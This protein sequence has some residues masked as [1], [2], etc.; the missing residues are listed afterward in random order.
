MIWLSILS[1]LKRFFYV[2]VKLILENK[3]WALIIILLICC[4]FQ[5]CQVNKLAGQIITLK[6]QHA[7]YITQQQ[8]ATEKA[9]VQAAQQEKVWA[10]QITKAEQ[11][12][13]AK[14]KQIQSDASAAQSAAN[15]LSKQLASAK[16]RLSAASRETIIEYTNTSSD[17][18]ESCI[19][20]YRN[21]AQKAD[22]HAADAERLSEA[23][24]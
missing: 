8:L 9:K 14:I 10:E 24:P 15:S 3:R 6:Q 23:W 21:V 7:D 22:E 17:I 1:A 18:L 12:Y 11:N 2:C 5:S 16:Q 20:E 19:T 13:N 4:L